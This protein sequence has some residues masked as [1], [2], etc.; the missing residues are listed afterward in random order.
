[1]AE[2]EAE[3]PPISSA[4]DTVV[5]TSALSH[6]L[7]TSAGCES[8]E[9]KDQA[10]QRM[11][12]ARRHIESIRRERGVNEDIPDEQRPRNFQDLRASCDL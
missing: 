7:A 4:H 1:M 3:R 11:M 10:E 6:L 2:A 5:T 12:D 9:V 8:Q